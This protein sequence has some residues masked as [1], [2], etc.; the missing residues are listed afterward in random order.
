MAAQLETPQNLDPRIRRTREL[1]Q[2]G[3]IHLLGT[4]EFEKISVQDI[5][6]AATVNRATFYAHYPDKFA[7]LECVVAGQFKALLT[8]RN[9]IF[10]GTCASALH[11]IALG[12]CDFLAQTPHLACSRQPHLEPHLEAAIVAVVSKM[13]LQGLQ[14][15]PSAK[16]TPELLAATVSGA[17]VGAARQ[18]LRSPNRPPSEQAAATITTLAAP[19]LAA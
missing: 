14:Q 11:G 16:A 8:A 15:H 7:L 17:L 5:A 13:L 9:V 10:D 4:Q 12:V 2:Q 18:W 6:E 3:L 1:L 19:I